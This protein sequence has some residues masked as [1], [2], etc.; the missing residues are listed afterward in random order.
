MTKSIA[1]TPAWIIRT[2]A[3]QRLAVVL[4][5]AAAAFLAQPNSISWHTRAVASWDLGALV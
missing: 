3:M 4:T 5:V 1:A 2:G